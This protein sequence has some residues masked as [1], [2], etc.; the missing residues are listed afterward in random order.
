MPTTAGANLGNILGRGNLL[1]WR[2]GW[3]G[4]EH[5][6]QANPTEIYHIIS[7]ANL[8]LGLVN[9]PFSSVTLCNIVLFIFCKFL[10]L[11]EV[12][13]DAVVR[14]LISHLPLLRFS[15]YLFLSRIIIY[16][17]GKFLSDDLSWRVYGHRGRHE[18]IACL[19]IYF[20]NIII[21]HLLPKTQRGY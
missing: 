16:D 20:Y 3:L 1:R 6:F 4:H 5:G 17:T 19:Y 18:Y 9:Y 2:G 13:E 12:E 7:S 10:R 21:Y 14:K 8:L 11:E 15:I